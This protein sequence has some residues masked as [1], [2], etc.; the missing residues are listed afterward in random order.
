M[1]S[2]AVIDYTGDGV[3]DRVIGIGF[4]PAVA[5]VV[6]TDSLARICWRVLGYSGAALWTDLDATSTEWIKSI[7]TSGITVGND[8]RVNGNT[9]TY[10]AIFVGEDAGYVATGTYTGDGTDDRNILTPFVPDLVICG[11][12][13]QLG[14]NVRHT[15]VWTTSIGGDAAIQWEAAAAVTGNFVQGVGTN[16]FQ[17]GTGLNANTRTYIWAAFRHKPLVI[18]SGTYIGTGADNREIADT[19]FLPGVVS[20]K[21]WSA[22]VSGPAVRTGLDNGD[23]ALLIQSTFGANVIQKFIVNGYEIGTSAVANTSGRRYAWFAFAYGDLG[24]AERGAAAPSAAPAL[25]LV[26]NLTPYN[27]YKSGLEMLNTY[28][29]LRI[30]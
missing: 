2:L 29:A 11:E 16:F 20:L 1:P 6:R 30:V 5:M 12:A 18:A 23:S 27:W 28:K 4:Q 15:Y 24:T 26:D 9:F 17:V 22:G 3:S 7:S 21:D 13:V 10:R 14:T 19:G 25:P 8:N